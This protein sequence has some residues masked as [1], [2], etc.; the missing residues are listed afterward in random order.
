MDTEAWQ[1]AIDRL[2]SL[3]VRESDLD[4]RFVRA[5]GKGGQ[6]VNKVA[7][8]VM[9]THKPTGLVV[10]CEDQR[11]QAQNRLRARER[12]AEK[13]AGFERARQAALL[14]AAQ[15]RKRQQRTRSRSAK[16]KMLKNK[17]H[18]SGIKKNRAGR[19]WENSWDS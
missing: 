5:G 10:R 2:A 4:E 7:T 18:R 16:E 8:C 13:L 3:G 1:R 14:H 15:K 17:K 6:N 12:L 11:S 19:G 9:L